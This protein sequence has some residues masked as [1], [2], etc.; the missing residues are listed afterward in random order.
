MLTPSHVCQSIQPSDRRLVQLYYK[1]YVLSTRL[2]EI[3]DLWYGTIT[4][5]IIHKEYI[6]YAATKIINIKIDNN[7]N[8]NNNKVYTPLSERCSQS[9]VF[10]FQ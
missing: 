7:N 5:D 4:F 9:R 3:C 8:N 2:L 10:V 6:G 1:S